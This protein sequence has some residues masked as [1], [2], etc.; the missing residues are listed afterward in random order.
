MENDDRP[1]L[2]HGGHTFV[3]VRHH[4]DYRGAPLYRCVRCHGVIPSW[5]IT[6]P[7]W[8]RALLGGQHCRELVPALTRGAT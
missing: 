3:P 1:D 7:G 4:P 8:L 5:A 2:A 6:S